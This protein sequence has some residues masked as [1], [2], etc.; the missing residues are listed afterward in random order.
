MFIN[1]GVTA[2]QH[3]VSQSDTEQQEERLHAEM[4]MK[5]G[6]KRDCGSTIATQRLQMAQFWV[7]EP[8]SKVGPHVRALLGHMPFNRR[9]CIRLPY[10][11]AG[12]LTS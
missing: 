10:V 7:D 3:V 8:S 6:R 1:S 9:Q 2:H 4:G 11:Q 12:K 5:Q